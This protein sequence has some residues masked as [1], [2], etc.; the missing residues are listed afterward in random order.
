ME[1]MKE[2]YGVVYL[3]TNNKNNKHYVGIT[4]RKGGFKRRYCARGN[5]IE[6]VYNY[7]IKRL[8]SNCK[9]NDH[10]F[11]A[12]EKYGFD[13]FSVDER[14]GIAYSKEELIEKEKYWIKHFDS[15]NNGYN[16]TLGGDGLEGYKPSKKTIQNR[17]TTRQ[18]NKAL[19]ELEFEYWLDHMDDPNCP[20]KCIT[21]TKEQASKYIMTG[22]IDIE[23][24]DE[25]L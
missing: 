14:F 19:E 24:E 6:R 13:S 3:I 23:F 1:E 15:F 21:L 17:I 20:Y 8:E 25:N 10:L 22:E 4:K 18:V 9:I 16:N 12:I 5:G 7:Y 11:R 2:E